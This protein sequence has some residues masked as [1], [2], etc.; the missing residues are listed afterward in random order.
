[1]RGRGEDRSSGS[2]EEESTESNGS[3]EEESSESMRGGMQHD[4]PNRLLL[5]LFVTDINVVP[6][7]GTAIVNINID[8][9]FNYP[10]PTIIHATLHI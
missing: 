5:E 7:R 1:M 3:G 4:L 2:G 9:K 6:V 10:R 8:R